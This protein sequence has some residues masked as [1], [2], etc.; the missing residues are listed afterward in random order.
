MEESQAMQVK[1]SQQSCNP[2]L[3]LGG[4]VS[5]GTTL[6]VLAVAGV[7]AGLI[8]GWDLL[9]AAGLSGLVLAVLPCVAMCALGL[10][11]SRMGQKDAGAGSVAGA[12]PPKEAQPPAT[13][14]TLANAVAGAVEKTRAP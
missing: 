7:G 2:V 1:A 12:V 11:A 3:T 13:A 10:C 14:E 4:R 5:Q 9:V 6:T 8:L